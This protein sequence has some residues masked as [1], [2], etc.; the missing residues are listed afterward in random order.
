MPGI[1]L[2]R[3]NGPS[4]VFRARWRSDGGAQVT[5]TTGTADETDAL[6]RAA[7]ELR[8]R[9]N[10]GDAPSLSPSSFPEDGSAAESDGGPT[11]APLPSL[12]PAPAPGSGS[13]RLLS[14]ALKEALGG[15][16]GVE[17]S[18]AP[19]PANDLPAP[20]PAPTEPA[21]GLTRG[22]RHLYHVAAKIGLYLIDAGLQRTV[23]AAG[24]EPDQMDDDE[25]ELIQEGCEELFQK[26]F[27][28]TTIGPLGKVALGSLCAGV[29]MYKSGKPLPAQPARLRSIQ[30]GRAEAPAAG[31]FDPL[32]PEDTKGGPGAA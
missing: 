24:R 28:R 29:G 8:R 25:R 26:A 18:A 31:A 19:P 9:S 11:P 13:R 30:G 6:V 22:E 14:E 2:F 5:W 3:S 32:P 15:A 7:A 17:T 1:N 27:G 4:S 20:A 10:G 23:R 16:A 21:P 12:S